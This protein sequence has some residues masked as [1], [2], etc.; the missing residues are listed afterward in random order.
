MNHRPNH[1]P[2]QPIESYPKAELPDPPPA[3]PGPAEAAPAAEASLRRPAEVAR[4]R[5]LD[6]AAVSASV[7]L[8]Y[9]FED[10]TGPVRR[11]EIRRLAV[12]EVG[13]IVA[14]YDEQAPIDIYDFLAAMTGLAP[15]VLR[16]LMDDDGAEV[17]ETARP[18]LPRWVRR[19]VFGETAA[20]T[21]SSG[22]GG[23]T[24]S[25]PPAP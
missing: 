20:E 25:P 12:A 2:S 10:E 14:A 17:L 22:G 1:R 13:A 24:R 23:A 4:L 8:R 11:I 21:T 7:E 18:L 15:A 16:G 9:P 19:T 5:F 6:P 3:D